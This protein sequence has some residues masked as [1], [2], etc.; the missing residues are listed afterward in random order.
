MM[1]PN[2]HDITEIRRVNQ[3]NPWNARRID[4]PNP[5]PIQPQRPN[6]S[7]GPAVAIVL[8]LL[9]LGVVLFVVAIVVSVLAGLLRQTLSNEELAFLFYALTLI[10]GLGALRLLLQWKN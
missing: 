2:R 4:D 3:P 8:A 6:P 10:A 5:A 9:I 7:V 1:D